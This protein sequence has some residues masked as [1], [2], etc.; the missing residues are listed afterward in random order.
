[1]RTAILL[2]LP[3]LALAACE[4]TTE[5]HAPSPDDVGPSFAT[6][7]GY[8]VTLLPDASHASRD[9]LQ[10]RFDASGGI[11]GSTTS[12]RAA[13]WQVEAGG[14]VTGPVPLGVLPAPFDAAR[15]WV[16]SSSATGD[17]VVGYADLYR[18]GPMVPWVWTKE[19]MKVLPRQEAAT[20]AWPLAVDDAGVIVGMVSFGVEGSQGAVWLPPYDVEPVLLPRMEE[21]ILN[22]GRGITEGVITGL[23]RSDTDAIVQWRIA[24]D[25]TVLSGPVQLAGADGILLSEVN[26]DFDIVG[27]YHGGGGRVAALYRTE[28][29]ERTDLGMLAGHIHS[30]ARGITARA[31][32]GAVRIAGYSGAGT[33]FHDTRAVVWSRGASG[34]VSGPFDLG[35]PDAYPTKMK[36]HRFQAAFAYAVNS[37]GWIA[38]YSRRGDGT[39]FATVW[40]STGDGATPPPG[41]G[42]AASF[43]FSCQ[44]TATCQFTDT[45]TPGSSAIT[46][47]RWESGDGQ[48]AS[49]QHVAFTYRDAGSYIVGLRVTDADGRSAEASA[50][51]KCSAHPR[52]GLRCSAC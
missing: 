9:E 44:N 13:R 37:H 7:P 29:A 3:V 52:H 4:H 35:L 33:D 47:W 24:G 22:G 26:R 34:A 32:D 41:I 38:G 30:H 46:A 1:M 40:L 16:M 39:F 14:H 6:A 5:P 2:A 27:V 10:L 17:V 31:A 15:Q 23:V 8:T 18:T 25:G 48:T 20:R 11:F 51:V 19:S 28:S 49:T 21:Y 45:S 12:N 42:P 43:G 50:T 36:G